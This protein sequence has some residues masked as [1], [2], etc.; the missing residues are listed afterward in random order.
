M[1][2]RQ[3]TKQLNQNNQKENQKRKKTIK[4]LYYIKVLSLYVNIYTLLLKC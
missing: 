1:R 4:F 3:F 2:M